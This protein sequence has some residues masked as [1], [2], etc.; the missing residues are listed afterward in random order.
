MLIAHPS[1]FEQTPCDVSVLCKQPVCFANT[2]RW[3][4]GI[5]HLPDN[6]FFL[7]LLCL[8]TTSS[9]FGGQHGPLCTGD[10]TPEAPCT[11]PGGRGQENE[12]K[13]LKTGQFLE[14]S[15]RQE[16]CWMCAHLAAGLLQKSG[17]ARWEARVVDDLLLPKLVGQ[18][19]WSCATLPSALRDLGVLTCLLLPV[20]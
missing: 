5:C 13:S 7:C 2:G 20:L 17:R 9:C 10:W 12:A 6:F 16:I 19:V 18:E 4:R 15:P 11:T 14:A 1:H 8:H 3:G